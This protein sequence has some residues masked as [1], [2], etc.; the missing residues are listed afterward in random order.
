MELRLLRLLPKK[1]Q[2][3]VVNKYELESYFG[4]ISVYE[5][6]NKLRHGREQGYFMVEFIVDDANKAHD[7]HA[8]LMN[9]SVFDEPFTGALNPNPA[10]LPVSIKPGVSLSDRDT[11]FILNKLTED[12]LEKHLRFKLSAINYDKVLPATHSKKPKK[13]ALPPYKGLVI[14]ENQVMY[15]EHPISLTRQQQ[16]LLRFLIAHKERTILKDELFNQRDILDT[17]ELSNPSATLSKLV[18]AVRVELRKV[19]HQKCIYNIPEEG[20]RFEL[21]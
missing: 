1:I 14:K 9:H 11:D 15:H 19:T 10:V 7:E 21:N 16:E 8:K 6:V 2:G 12:K 3:K 4:D 17:S 5:L 13:S 18:S 20:W